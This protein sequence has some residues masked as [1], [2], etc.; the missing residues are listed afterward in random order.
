MSEKP[1]SVPT[2]EELIHKA[3]EIKHGSISVEYVIQDGKIIRKN[4]TTK[5]GESLK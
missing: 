1:L 3:A 5:E 4:T 2:P